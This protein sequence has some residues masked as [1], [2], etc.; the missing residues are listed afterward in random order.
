MRTR[1]RALSS[2]HGSG[3]GNKHKTERK[4]KKTSLGKEERNMMAALAGSK[5]H[6]NQIWTRARRGDDR[7]MGMVY[8]SALA[9]LR[10]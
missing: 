9:P 4:E 6:L 3:G 8:D 7:H 10:T 1:L 2:C 5:E